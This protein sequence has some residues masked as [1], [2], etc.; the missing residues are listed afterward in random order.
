MQW[1]HRVF[2]I[3]LYDY[4]TDNGLECS[5][6][7][8]DTLEST[9]W[10]HGPKSRRPILLRLWQ[11]NFACLHFMINCGS[12]WV[13]QTIVILAV[14]KKSKWIW[15]QASN[16]VVTHE[17]YKSFGFKS[18]KI[19]LKTGLIKKGNLDSHVAEKPRNS[20]SF[21]ISC[22]WLSYIIR[23]NFFVFL[24]DLLWSLLNPM[25]GF[26]RRSRMISHSF[27]ILLM[28]CKCSARRDR[29]AFLK[30]CWARKRGS[31]KPQQ[32]S[33]CLSLACTLSSGLN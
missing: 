15:W 21:G 4:H 30:A 14:L 27:L 6:L 2:I 29:I 20:P 7:V 13:L 9:L 26:V 33:P 17:Y 32:T 1:S 10:D 19:W 8:S 12:S 31:Q 22:K 3:R 28:L 24:L 23:N 5:S 25:V 11:V 18:E 16:K